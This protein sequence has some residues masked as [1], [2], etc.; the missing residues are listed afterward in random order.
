MANRQ[1]DWGA[2]CLPN[3]RADPEAI[4]EAAS[5]TDAPLRV[6]APYRGSV[7]VTAD[8]VTAF[9]PDLDTFDS[10]RNFAASCRKHAFLANS[11]RSCP[12]GP[13]GPRT[14]RMIWAMTTEQ[15][16]YRRADPTRGVMMA[17][18]RGLN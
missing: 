5:K 4:A 11:E 12:T 18:L 16:D 3:D 10:G 8:A 9:A 15:Q 1:T 6:S 14:A 7:P 13:R 17:T 2:F